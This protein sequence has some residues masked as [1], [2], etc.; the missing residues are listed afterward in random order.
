MS[1]TK[2]QLMLAFSYMSYYGITHTGSAKKNAELILKKMK[3]ALKTWKPFQEDDWEVVWGPAVYTMPFTIFNDAMMYVIQKKGA[4]GE[5]VIAIRGTNPVSISD[6]LF[7]DFMVSAMK[8]WPYASVEGRI[9]KIS[10]S[11]SYGLKTLQ[12]LKPKSHIPGENKTILQFLNEKIGPEGKA[13]ICVTG[14]SK[15]GA[16]SSTLA[17][18]L[19]DIQG[20]KLSQNIDISTIPF[21]GPTAGNADFADYFDDCLGD[22]CTRIANSL[23]I[24]PYA[25]NTNSLKKLKSIYISEQASVKPLLYQRALIRAMIAETKGKKYKQIKAETPPLEGNINPILIEYLVQ[26]AYQHVVGYPELM[27]MMD[28]I[29]LTDIFEDAIAGLL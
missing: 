15:G 26:A 28:D 6:W 24:V 17:L 3:E 14:H 29:P 19:K 12:K 18:W 27:G 1:Y 22:Q 21:A 25:W 2:E 7:N 10:E 13:K 4:E 8:K 23:D 11:T 5:Y 16:L 9:L 20:V